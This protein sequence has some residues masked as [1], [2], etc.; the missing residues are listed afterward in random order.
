[1]IGY[2]PA[3]AETAGPV[4]LGT[5]DS[6]LRAVISCLVLC[7]AFLVLPTGLAAQE[8]D[9]SGYVSYGLLPGMGFKDVQS[10][11]TAR[12]IEAEDGTLQSE[13]PEVEIYRNPPV[14][15][16]LEFDRPVTR[17]NHTTLLVVRTFAP[18]AD[19]DPSDLRDSLL[20]RF[21]EPLAGRP[22]LEDGFLLGPTVWVDEACNIE[23]TVYRKPA[24]WWEDQEDMICVETRRLDDSKPIPERHH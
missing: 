19:M 11:M 20:Q 16:H 8:R 24:R 13:R 15:I 14:S 4:L 12:G 6:P 2:G 18:V 9:C 23:V 5:E 3:V 17:K 10:L 7:V 22:N 1:M 21:G